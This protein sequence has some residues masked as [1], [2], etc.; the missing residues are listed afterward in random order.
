MARLFDLFNVEVW[1]Y[2]VQVRPLPCLDKLQDYHYFLP[3][4]YQFLAN[5]LTISLCLCKI[6]LEPIFLCSKACYILSNSLMTARQEG[7]ATSVTSKQL[8]R[9]LHKPTLKQPECCPL[10]PHTPLA[11][12]DSILAVLMLVW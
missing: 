8:S 9:V 1:T 3:I 2:G 4:L 10:G 11:R 7:G 12:G 5:L 6:F